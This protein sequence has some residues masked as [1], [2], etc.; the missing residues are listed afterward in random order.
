MRWG[1]S[2]GGAILSIAAAGLLAACAG[3]GDG[4]AEKKVAMT[5]ISYN[6]IAGWADDQ[7]F[8]AVAAFRNSCP[9]LASGPDS[10]IATDGGEKIVTAAEW[11]RICDAAAG[12]PK[13]D[14]RAARRF[15][16]ENF[17]PL[18]VQAPGSFTGYFEPE[19]RGSRAPSRLFTVPVYR[20]PP[21]LTDKPYYTRAEIEQGVLKG[22]GLEVA[23]VQ[24]AV[25]LF[26][27]QIGRAHV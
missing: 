20:K 3:T 2:S 6:E 19:L 10:K 15:F 11:K 12:V 27:A 25:S 26:E 17:R 5:P 21:D 7:H 24:D 23:W 4:P 8:D 1:V 22:K 14:N 13:G 18:V 9:K 16:E